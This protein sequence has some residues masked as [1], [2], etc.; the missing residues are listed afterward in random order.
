MKRVAL[1]LLFFFVLKPVYGQLAK[2][3]FVRMPDSLN[4]LLTSVNRADFIDFME[5]KMKA[6]VTNRMESKSEM[7]VLASD[8]I[9]IQMS[10]VS[11]WQLKVLPVGNQ[12][13]LCTVSTVNGPASDSH[14][15]FFSENWQELEVADYLPSPPVLKDFILH[16]ADTVSSIQTQDA[17]RQA[18]LLLMRMDF[19]AENSDL[20]FVFTTPEYMSKEAS[21]LIRPYIRPEV[22]YCW[23]NEKFVP[24]SQ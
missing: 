20:H 3:Y 8:Y 2:D 6:E 10:S 22:V 5:S 16:S 18:D 7:K 13:I 21:S 14:I 1:F 11:T 9:L 24:V 4:W 12:N 15:R 19:S 17:I 23:K